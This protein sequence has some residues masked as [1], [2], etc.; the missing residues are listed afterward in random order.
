MPANAGPCR[1]GA[2]GTAPGHQLHVTAAVEREVA[3]LSLAGRYPAQMPAAQHPV[4]GAG[5]LDSSV[6]VRP[7]HQARAVEARRAGPAEAIPL[8]SLV[9]GPPQR[10]E[11]PR[12]RGRRGGGW[13]QRGDQQHHESGGQRRHDGPAGC[14][15]DPGRQSG[16]AGRG[17]RAGR[18]G[19]GRGCSAGG[20][21]RNGGRRAGD[22][23]GELRGLTVANSPNRGQGEPLVG[24]ATCA[25]VSARRHLPAA[26]DG[27]PGQR[28]TRGMRVRAPGRS[29][30]AITRTGRF[31]PTLQPHAG[32]CLANRGKRPAYITTAMPISHTGLIDPTRARKEA[33]NP[34]AG[35][36]GRCGSVTLLRRQ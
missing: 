28:C 16:H 23:G 24:R 2:E 33:A 13:C 36:P 32:F 8:P 17:R 14:R 30:T 3:A 18:T 27:R 15:S 34:G 26:S 20:N 10:D 11:P 1:R 19:G 22:Y 9:F 35:W 4:G 21:G 6:R 25:L 29:L 5:Q 31:R 7:H 12:R